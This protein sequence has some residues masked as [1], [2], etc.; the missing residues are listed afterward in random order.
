MK[1]GYQLVRGV[2]RS[3]SLINLFNRSESTMRCA[4]TF[5]RCDLT[6]RL[7]HTAFTL[8][9]HSIIKKK[10]N[11]QINT[12]LKKKTWPDHHTV[13]KSCNCW[14]C[15]FLYTYVNFLSDHHHHVFHMLGIYN[16]RSLVCCKITEGKIGHKYGFYCFLQI[17]YVNIAKAKRRWNKSFDGLRYREDQ[18]KRS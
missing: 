5:A 7:K 8:E 12:E 13:T 4:H 14:T 10:R 3:G 18:L 16:G 2:S 1:C 15:F 11:A 6:S 9:N 17:S